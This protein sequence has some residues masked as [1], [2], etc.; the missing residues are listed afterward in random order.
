MPLYHYSS[1]PEL[2]FLHQFLSQVVRHWLVV[3]EEH[4]V[5]GTPLGQ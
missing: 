2:L 1:I 4:A 5:T 3:I